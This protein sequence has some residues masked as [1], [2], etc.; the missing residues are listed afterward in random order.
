[1]NKQPVMPDYSFLDRPEV[2][3]FVFFPRREWNKPPRGAVDY[4]VPI[5]AGVS[6]SARLY[7]AINSSATILYF[8]GNGE[9]ACDYDWFAPDYNRLGLSLFVSDYRGYGRSSGEPTITGMVADSLDVFDF[10]YGNFHQSKDRLFVMGRSL[11]SISALT[12]AGNRADKVSGLIV[13]SGF[14]AITRILS[15]L[16]FTYFTY[17]DSKIIE[18]E[19]VSITFVASIVLP[20]LVIHGGRDTLIPYNEGILLYDTLGSSH[21]KMVTIEGAGHNDI[22]LSGKEF[23]F[24]A[25]KDFISSVLN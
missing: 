10:F 6:V 12:V 15:H 5:D 20:A 16:G 11:G 23:Y 2:L 8:H 17:D 1:M 13:E 22:M 14:P 21:K 24:K 4:I 18:F 3:Q 19:R 25:I 9:I 7:P